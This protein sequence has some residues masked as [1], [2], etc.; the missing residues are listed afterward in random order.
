[1]IN[2]TT[3]EDRRFSR[4]GIRDGADIMVSDFIFIAVWTGFFCGQ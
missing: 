3:A 1:M 4:V 2:G